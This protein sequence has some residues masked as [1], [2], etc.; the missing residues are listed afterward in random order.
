MKERPA[1]CTTTQG[2]LGSRHNHFYRDAAVLDCWKLVCRRWHHL[3]A[4]VLASVKVYMRSQS[5][6]LLSIPFHPW[7]VVITYLSLLAAAANDRFNAS[8]PCRPCTQLHALRKPLCQRYLQASGVPATTHTAAFT[9]SACHPVG[10]AET[11]CEPH[12]LTCRRLADSHRAAVKLAHSA[13]R[14]Q[15]VAMWSVCTTV[16]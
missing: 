13:R 9:A 3:V 14:N 16:T 10:S 5:L 12:V 1:S 15:V 7:Q 11:L 2:Q 4:S 6:C 8:V